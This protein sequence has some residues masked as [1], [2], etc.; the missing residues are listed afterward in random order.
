[1]RIY[2]GNLTYR[3]N[4]EDVRKAFAQ[5]GEV[6]SVDLAVDRATGRS[7]GY[8]F[9]EMPDE[10][11]AQLAIAKLNRKEINSRVVSV[12]AATEEQAIENQPARNDRN[13][14][15]NR[16]NDRKSSRNNTRSNAR[17]NARSNTA[18]RP[19]SQDKISPWDRRKPS[20]RR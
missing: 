18:E 2:V 8:A 4:A 20:Q 19:S 7:A 14:E 9:V 12:H 3:S 13:R 16:G 5:F 10:E 1:M 6:T 17:S 15:N 11:Q